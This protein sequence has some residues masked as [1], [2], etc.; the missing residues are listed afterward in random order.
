M[1]QIAIL[2]V[3]QAISDPNASP[4]LEFNIPDALLR[5]QK[6]P[7]PSTSTSNSRLDVVATA[8]DGRFLA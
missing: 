8:P 6:P 2:R 5:T 1:M 7:Q 3:T 4:V